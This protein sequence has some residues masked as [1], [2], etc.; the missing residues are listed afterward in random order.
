MPF[1]WPTQRLDYIRAMRRMRRVP[2]G[3]SRIGRSQTFKGQLPISSRIC[4]RKYRG[5]IVGGDQVWVGQLEDPFG[6]IWGL[7]EKPDTR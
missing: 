2:V 7:V 6:N 4:C 5:P 3:R 1:V